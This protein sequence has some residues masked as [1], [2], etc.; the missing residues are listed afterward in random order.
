[1]WKLFYAITN[2][3]LA[4][5]I[6]YFAVFSDD[7]WIWVAALVC[8]VFYTGLGPAIHHYRWD[9][10]DARFFFQRLFFGTLGIYGVMFFYL[11]VARPLLSL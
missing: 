3:L 4:Q 11:L 1:M 2:I 8:F 5:P 7:Q 10:G 9:V 6:G